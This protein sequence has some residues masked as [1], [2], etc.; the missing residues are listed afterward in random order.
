MKNFYIKAVIITLFIA[1][2]AAACFIISHPSPTS[3]ADESGGELLASFLSK[4]GITVSQ[5]ALPD[6]RYEVY[7]ASAD[8]SAA[9]KSLFAERLFGGTSAMSGDGTEFTFGS[10]KLTISSASFSYTAKSLPHKE[11][12]GNITADNAGKKAQSIAE[13]HG[14]DLSGSIINCAENNGT[15]TAV[16]TKSFY[17]LPIFND[18]MTLTMSAEGLKSISGVWFYISDEKK[19]AAKSVPSA[20]TE[21]INNPEC[22]SQA[23]IS[24]MELGYVLLDPTQDKTKLKPVWRI[25]L[26]DGKSFMINA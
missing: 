6:G 8:N 21:L 19:R 14:F 22:P 4:H 16:I 20:L 5:N 13:G 12:L 25:S 26:S 11:E 9:D 2:C 10:D 1:I 15:Y 3:L 17:G 24:R 7:D 23:E 18:E